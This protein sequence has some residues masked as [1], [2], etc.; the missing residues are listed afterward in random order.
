MT[1][2]AKSKTSLSI[3][4]DDGIQGEID[5]AQLIPFDGVFALLV[6]AR[7]FARVRVNEELGT[8]G[9]PNGADLDSDLLY[10]R[11]TGRS[12]QLDYVPADQ[13]AYETRWQQLLALAE[14]ERLLKQ[15]DQDA[16]VLPAADRLAA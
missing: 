3:E 16:V 7:Y 13:A 5:I 12:V 2:C 11:I 15:P 10:S 14:V 4:F 8:I 1:S 6:D 9:W